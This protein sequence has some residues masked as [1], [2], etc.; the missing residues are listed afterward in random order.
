MLE[1]ARLHGD[2]GDHLGFALLD[3]AHGVRQ[4]DADVP[5]RREEALDGGGRRRRA[6]RQQYQHVDVGAG[7]ERAAAVAADRDGR[8]LGGH[9]ALGPDAANHAVDEARMVA[10]Q[11]RRVGRRHERRLAARRGAP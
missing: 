4:L 10:Q 9:R 11:R 7:E 8:Q 6:V 5:Q 2:V 1:Q 3:R